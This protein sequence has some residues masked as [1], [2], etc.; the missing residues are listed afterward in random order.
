MTVEALSV[1]MFS[2]ADGAEDALN[3]IRRLRSH[4][5]V[6]VHDGAIVTWPLDQMGPT[7]RQLVDLASLGA[8]N[9]QFW[10][11]LFGV[12]FTPLFGLAVGGAFSALGGRFRDF[13][14]DD[15]FIRRV[16]STVTPGTSALF[17]MTSD[18]ALDR[19]AET[20]KG[21][22]PE[23][24]ATNLTVEQERKLRQT[25]GRVSRMYPRLSH[26]PGA[27]GNCA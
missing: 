11:L 18:A 15:D 7:T 5:L 16:R 23:I 20:V 6:K 21:M 24:I 9:G 1:L 22:K 14:M 2:V 10:S 8:M 12:M 27:A 26:R 17:L 25:F 13:G 3:Q 19:V 4:H